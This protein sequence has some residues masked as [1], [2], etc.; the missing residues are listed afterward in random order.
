LPDVISLD[1]KRYGSKTSPRKKGMQAALT[2]R[3]ANT[4]TNFNEDTFL[5][6]AN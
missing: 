5:K 6:V 3:A 4:G 1:N 2:E